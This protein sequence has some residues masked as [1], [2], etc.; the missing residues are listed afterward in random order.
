MS[1]I[2]S[3]NSR[4]DGQ[5]PT[6]DVVNDSFQGDPL[7]IIVKDGRGQHSQGIV[8]SE[9]Q[10]GLLVNA[11]VQRVPSVMAIPPKRSEARGLDRARSAFS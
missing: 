9:E 1:S 6:I 11:I 8:L 5:R 2:V 3:L 7:W 4:A 10:A